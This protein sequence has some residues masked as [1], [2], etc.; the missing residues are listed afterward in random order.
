MPF[1]TQPL[2]VKRFPF[3]GRWQ[4]LATH[5]QVNA[6]I[7][8][9]PAFRLLAHFTDTGGQDGYFQDPPLVR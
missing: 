2:L 3:L 5:E 6:S 4:A 7:P 8:R 9:R 1:V